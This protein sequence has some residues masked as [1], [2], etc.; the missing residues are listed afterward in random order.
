M[1]I[2]FLSVLSLVVAKR[3]ASSSRISFSKVGKLLIPVFVSTLP[4]SYLFFF[5]RE[6]NFILRFDSQ[7]TSEKAKSGIV[8]ADSPNP[9]N[10][11]LLLF[12][13]NYLFLIID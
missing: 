9:I 11:F 8:T 13:L 4:L 7:D 10:I 3:L 6:F 12:I 1:K 5:K 2:F